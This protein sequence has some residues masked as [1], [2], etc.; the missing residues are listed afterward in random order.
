V[1]RIAILNK[2]RFYSKLLTSKLKN[3][4]PGKIRRVTAFEYEDEIIDQL[5]KISKYDV[6]FIGDGICSDLKKLVHVLRHTKCIAN[7]KRN[8]RNQQMVDAGVKWIVPKSVIFDSYSLGPDD[9]E[10]LRAPIDQWFLSR[11]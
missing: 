7:S 3:L 2:D 4:Y 6:V 1:I 10:E 8:S 9:L 5:D 11:K